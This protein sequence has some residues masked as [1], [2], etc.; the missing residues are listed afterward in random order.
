[1]QLQ[2]AFGRYAQFPDFEQLFGRGGNPDLGAEDATHA[3]VALETRLG[4]DASVR[5]EAY[6]LHID[7][8]FVN[9]QA[10]WRLEGTWLEGPDPDAALQNALAGRS[11]GLEVVLQRRATT[12]PSGWIAYTFGHSRWRTDAGLELDG[13]FDQRHTLTVFASWPLG[14]TFHVGTKYR[15]GSGF[16]VAGF[17]EAGAGGV[18]LSSQRNAYRPGGYSRWDVRADK[19][20]VFDRWKL[21]LYG[22]VL[23]VLNH[24]QRRVT[25]LDAL[26]V[27]TGRVTLQTDT[28]FPL[29]PSVGIAVDF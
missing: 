27:R 11:R 17:Y 6:D 19:A 5:V 25:G 12:G 4:T 13:D 10:E 7:G 29:L 26:D 21:T 2:A 8:G 20:F 24:T 3:L 22:E 23:N 18:F 15:L 16:P 1:V 14:R 28:L 9:T